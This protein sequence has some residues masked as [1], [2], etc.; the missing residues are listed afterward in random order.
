MLV[1]APTSVRVRLLSD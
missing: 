1:G